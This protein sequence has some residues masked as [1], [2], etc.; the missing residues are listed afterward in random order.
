M[1]EILFTKYQGTGNDFVI[2]NNFN[3]NN[4]L[5][6][7]QINKICDRRLGIGA[8]GLILINPSKKYDFV[9]K[10][11]NADGNES[12]MCGNGGR[13][14]SLFY[15]N[16]IKPANSI[17][18]NSIDGFHTSKIISKD[19]V[20]LKML[21]TNR[22]QIYSKNKFE[23]NTG[24]PH[25]INFVKSIHKIDFISKAKKIRY[26][27][28]YNKE[29]INVNFVETL[30]SNLIFVRTYERGVEN[31]TLSCGTGVVA[32]ALS[33]SILMKK[34]L[35]QHKVTIQTKGGK[36]KVSFNKKSHN[37][38]EDIYLT[39]ECKKVFTGKMFL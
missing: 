28:T 9:M 36:L 13:C 26:S 27:P 5:S 20:E 1:K 21:N 7:L 34:K 29:G 37:I 2:L 38:F 11:F 6:Q 39:G 15:F 16:E 31:E 17:S 35:G 18:F 24:S 3:R 25:F 33:F 19:T 14:A 23:I 32:S 10:Y 12:T 8:D 4:N 22:I 30:N